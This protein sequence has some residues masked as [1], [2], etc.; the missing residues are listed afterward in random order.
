MNSLDKSPPDI[1]NYIKQ[2]QEERDSYWA[3]LASIS[4]FLGVGMG[5]EKT[6]AQQYVQRIQ[7]G[8]LQMVQDF[9]SQSSTN[10]KIIL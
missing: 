7:E 6:T 8:I 4:L 2:L 10:K 5:E 1:E 9:S 3:A